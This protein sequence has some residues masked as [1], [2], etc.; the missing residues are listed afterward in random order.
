MHSYFYLNDSERLTCRSDAAL[1]CS[2]SFG[3]FVGAIFAAPFSDLGGRELAITLL[4]SPRSAGV[5][6]LWLILPLLAGVL[7]SFLQS[8]LPLLG[9]SMVLGIPFGYTVFFLQRFLGEMGLRAAV[10]L[11][12]PNVAAFPG[13]FWFF[14]R[15]LRRAWDSLLQDFI[16]ATAL[17]LIPALAVE[18]T[19]A[20]FFRELINLM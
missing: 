10:L 20:P 6:V 1:L 9:L 5:G 13:L 4:S 11:L 7:C 17:C 12:A 18:S 14:S 2:F 3:V 15:L 16:L 19:L 8:S